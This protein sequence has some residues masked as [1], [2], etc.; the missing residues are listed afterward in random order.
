MD[1]AQNVQ[2]LPGATLFTTHSPIA[3]VADFYQKQLPASGWKLDGKPSIGDKAG[4]LNFKQG[5]SQLTVVSMLG[6][7]GTAVRLLLA[8][9][10]RS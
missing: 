4:L 3:Q 5:T 1:D 8:T 7:Q 10:R 6:D 9:A 2:R